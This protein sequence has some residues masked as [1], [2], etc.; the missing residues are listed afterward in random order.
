MKCLFMTCVDVCRIIRDWWFSCYWLDS[1]L[2]MIVKRCFWCINMADTSNS[3]QMMLWICWIINHLI[4]WNLLSI[5]LIWIDSFCD[6]RRR[7][8]HVNKGWTFHFINWRL[9]WNLTSHYDVS[10][11]TYIPWMIRFSNELSDIIVGRSHE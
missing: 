7:N 5:N 11:I 9:S 3:V 4:Y 8:W 1:L 2:R 6:L 10:L